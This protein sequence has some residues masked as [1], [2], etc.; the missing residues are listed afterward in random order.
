MIK[1]IIRDD[2]LN[3]FTKVDDVEK[4]YSDI[5]FFPI[6]FAVIPMV[7]DVSTRG[8]CSDTKGNKTPMWIGDNIEL[9]NWVKSGIEK[10]NADVLLHGI[11]HSYKY[12][13]GKRHA[14]MEWRNES[15]L[16]EEICEIRKRLETLFDY[17]IT[18]FVAPSNKISKY[19]MKCVTHNNL[20][21]SGIVPLAF[22][23][24]ITCKNLLC[25]TKRW[26]LRVKD[27]L[28]YP[29]I[30]EYSDHKEM[31]ACLMQGYDYLIE[32]FHYCERINSPMA[33]N[34]HYWHLRDNERER[35]ELFRFVDY[36]MEHGAVPSRMSEVL[37]DTI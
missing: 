11:T 33:V 9:C 36:A 20:N 15:N 7:M 6:S 2:D 24:D 4:I 25:Y 34:V 16:S 22:K 26:F 32:M 3:Y 27:R 30:L 23:R 13:N 31:N 12:L 5:S 8:A 37:N 21:F 10:G 1:L 19:G 29:N 28:P 14:E 18:V 17:E 35:Y